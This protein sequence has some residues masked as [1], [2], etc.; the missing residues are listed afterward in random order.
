MAD[1]RRSKDNTFFAKKNHFATKK[2]EKTKS[3]ILSAGVARLEGLGATIEVPGGAAPT[4]RE[5]VLAIPGLV[6]LYNMTLANGTLFQDYAKTVPSDNLGEKVVVV[7]NELPGG[8]DLINSDGAN[9]FTLAA[10]GSYVVPVSDGSDS[11]FLDPVPTGLVFDSIT[12][13]QQPASPA[14]SATY[15]SHSNGPSGRLRTNFV[16]EYIVGAVVIEPAVAGTALLRLRTNDTTGTLIANASINA[17]APTVATS[18]T[19]DNV[20]ARLF[21]IVNGGTQSPTGVGVIAHAIKTGASGFSVAEANTVAAYFNE[22]TGG[23]LTL[24]TYSGW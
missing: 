18:T 10:I 23:S 8:Q 21:A 13:I 9:A 22:L 17:A 20:D 7:A 5:Q 11:F 16:P 15:L 14:S 6:G 24:G 4:L 3:F 2:T 1:V 19:L 12:L